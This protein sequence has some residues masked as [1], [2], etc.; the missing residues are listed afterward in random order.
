MK[1]LM[2]L[3]VSLIIFYNVH[4]QNLT[5]NNDGLIF[6]LNQKNDTIFKFPKPY[7][8]SIMDRWNCDKTYRIMCVNILADMEDNIEDNK[9]VIGEFIKS[10]SYEKV[11]TG[12]IKHD[13]ETTT[14]E[15][16]PQEIHFGSN[17]NNYK[18]S[19]YFPDMFSVDG[20]SL[21]NQTQNNNKFVITYINAERNR[22]SGY[23]EMD[24]YW[25]SKTYKD[26]AKYT[27]DA[28]FDTDLIF[29][30]VLLTVR[31]KYV[32]INIPCVIINTK[33]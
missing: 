23:I 19:Y 16:L 24:M 3:I 21:P 6:I 26:K 25:F 5:N 9:L 33:R 28:C 7:E 14:P 27:N 8:I 2:L 10:L 22:M 20:V 15:N 18:S 4:S 29:P 1:K 30:T 11:F 31:L 13:I 12:V 17:K 32:F